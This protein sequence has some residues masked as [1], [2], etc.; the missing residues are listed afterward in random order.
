LLV[1]CGSNAKSETSNPTL[2]PN[3][4]ACTSD[5][6]SNALKEVNTITDDYLKTIDSAWEVARS[7]NA[8]ENTRPYLAQL[9]EYQNKLWGVYYYVS[10]SCFQPIIE[11]TIQSNE[12]EILSLEYLSKGCVECARQG[13]TRSME[14]GDSCKEAF[15]E[16]TLSRDV[17]H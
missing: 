14:I 6:V 7:T 1:S 4:D 3:V 10:P 9:K 17:Q 8:E 12:Y 16:F 2:T 11:C 5:L 13:L 15:S